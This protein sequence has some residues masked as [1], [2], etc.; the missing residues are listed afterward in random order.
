LPTTELRPSSERGGG[1][2]LVAAASTG[3]RQFEAATG[4][5][6]MIFSAVVGRTA[7]AVLL[8]A[9]LAKGAQPK[10]ASRRSAARCAPSGSSTT[11]DAGSATWLERFERGAARA[12]LLRFAPRVLEL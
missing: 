12:E 3:K 8:L 11:V 9:A 5:D 2:F 10:S 4:L 7:L 1:S 6:G